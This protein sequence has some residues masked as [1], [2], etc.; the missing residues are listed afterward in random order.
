MNGFEDRQQ[1]GDEFDSAEDR[2]LAGLLRTVQA[3]ANPAVWTRARARLEIA[4]ARRLDGFLDWLTRPIAMA[5]ATA[6]LIVSLGAGLQIIRPLVDS[7]TTSPAT[8]SVASS[9]ATSLIESLL[10]SSPAASSTESSAPG[11]AGPALR[12]SGGSS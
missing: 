6:A 4:P 8:E 2:R 7:N 9:E 5:A 10:E 12:D 1:P 3:E 11:S